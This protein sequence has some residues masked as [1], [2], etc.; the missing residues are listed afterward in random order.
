MCC[1][2]SDD[3]VTSLALLR[4]ILFGHLMT[5]DC[6][7]RFRFILEV[8]QDGVDNVDIYFK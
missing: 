1:K 3:T 7:Y 6:K 5:K 2:C 4:L 8:W